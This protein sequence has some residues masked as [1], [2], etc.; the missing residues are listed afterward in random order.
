MSVVRQSVTV[1][2][3]PEE[4]WQIIA[5]PRNL[6]RWNSHIRAVRD[7]PNGTLKPGDRYSTEVRML[8]VSVTVKAEVLELQPERYSKI[9]LSGPLEATVRTYVQPIGTHQSRIEHEVD[10]T[11]RGG[12]LGGVVAKAVRLVGAPTILK[13]GLRAQKE[14]VEQG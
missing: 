3:P 11:F 2:A 9:V 12:P 6:P 10:Y 4:V 13:R 1:D 14:Q 7:A 5:D 8:G